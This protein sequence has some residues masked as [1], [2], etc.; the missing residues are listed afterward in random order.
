MSSESMPTEAP[1]T[2]QPRKSSWHM[3]PANLHTK[4]P[5]KNLAPGQEELRPYPPPGLKE[6]ATK[7]AHLG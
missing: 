2:T 6:K 5:I 7:E 3:A 4:V 1:A